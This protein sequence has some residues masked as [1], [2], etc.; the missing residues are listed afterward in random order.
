MD[1]L[2]T[3]GIL[4]TVLVALAMTLACGTARNDGQQ[5]SSTPN[6]GAAGQPS[7][8]GT[9]GGRNNSSG[10]NSGGIAGAPVACTGTEVSV[11]KRLVRLSLGQ[12]ANAVGSLTSQAA[13]EKLRSTYDLA[14]AK[15]R[16]FPPL[17]SPRE[18]ST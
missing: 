15:H 14:D 10:G 8:V 9:S 1:A 5:P 17:A 12:V 13:T 7:G 4:P 3:R 2:P 6:A 16:T 18:G 11:P